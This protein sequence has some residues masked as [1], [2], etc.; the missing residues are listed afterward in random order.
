[1]AS[2]LIIAQLCARWRRRAQPRHVPLIITSAV[3]LSC[4]A[5]LVLDWGFSQAYVRLDDTHIAA[6]DPSVMYRDPTSDQRAFDGDEAAG[7]PGMGA[8]VDG[9]ASAAADDIS[10][11]FEDG[12]SASGEAAMAGGGM[13]YAEVEDVDGDHDEL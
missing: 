3:V 1:M 10:L 4:L 12:A 8:F 6:S 11:S 2:T 7:A 9:S 13:G 5:V